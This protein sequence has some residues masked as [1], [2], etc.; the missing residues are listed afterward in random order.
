MSELYIGIDPGASLIRG[1][2]AGVAIIS[3]DGRALNTFQAPVVQYRINKSKKLR[4]AMDT[5]ALAREISSTIV[6][7]GPDRIIGTIEHPA[8]A[9]KKFKVP[10][11]STCELF[12]HYGATRAVLDR[13]CDYVIPIYPISWKAY[14][15]LTSDKK[16]SLKL[17]R[18]RFPE[19]DLRYIA[20]HNLAEALL[21]A[22]YGRQHENERRLIAD[23]F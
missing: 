12:M 17:A 10:A 19:V 18:H 3:Q 9:P 8:A 7:N 16:T 6:R 23:M 20:D 2:G 1:H 22:D 13:F 15:K 11:T 5:E 14:F 4:T 21:L